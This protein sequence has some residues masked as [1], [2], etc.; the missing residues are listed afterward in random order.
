MCPAPPPATAG[1][2]SPWWQAQQETALPDGAEDVCN[3]GCH[4]DLW[5]TLGTRLVTHLMHSSP[6]TVLSA[7]PGTQSDLE[8]A[9]TNGVI[10]CA[11]CLQPSSTAAQQSLPLPIETLVLVSPDP[12]ASVT[13]QPGYV[14]VDAGDQFARDHTAA[15]TDAAVA[16]IH[17]GSTVWGLDHLLAHGGSA[18]LPASLVEAHLARGTLHRLDAPTFE[19]RTF[20][21]VSEPAATRWQHLHAALN[22]PPW[23]PPD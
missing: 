20:F 3:I 23:T 19:R 16:K 11:L 13:H 22:A 21:L 1:A 12:A 9:L 14:Y 6:R 4:P 8:Q 10:D 18:Y 15:Y 5:P 7:V 17:L 2:L